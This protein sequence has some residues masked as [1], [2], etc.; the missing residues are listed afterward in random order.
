MLTPQRLQYLAGS[1]ISSWHH[2]SSKSPPR[3]KRAAGA[4]LCKSA[5]SGRSPLSTHT[6]PEPNLQT[7]GWVGYT[8]A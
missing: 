1:R 5:W 4:R 7:A 2:S 6:P 3:G 8:P